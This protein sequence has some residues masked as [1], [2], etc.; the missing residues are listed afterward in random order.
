MAKLLTLMVIM[1]ILSGGTMSGWIC[2]PTTLPHG[3][4]K[5]TIS[6][7][8]HPTGLDRGAGYFYSHKLTA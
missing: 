2:L 4:H 3:D 8:E 6:T 7:F 1:N 5:I